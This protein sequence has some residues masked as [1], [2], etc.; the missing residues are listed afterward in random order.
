V[1]DRTEQRLVRSSFPPSSYT[2]DGTPSHLASGGQSRRE[3]EEDEV[4]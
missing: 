1:S 2:R 3:D 4:K